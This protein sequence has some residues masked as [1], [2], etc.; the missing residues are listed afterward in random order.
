[1]PPT[2]KSRAEMIRQL[3]DHSV[4]QAVAEARPYW[5]REL[6]EH[7]FVGYRK[8]S[9]QQLRMEMQLRGLENPEEAIDDD[10]SDDPRIGQY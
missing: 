5:L 1:M 7:G 2:G 3:V 4:S 8:F 6:F 10:P 9:D